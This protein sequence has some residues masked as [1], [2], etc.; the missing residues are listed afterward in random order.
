MADGW[1]N[2]YLAPVYA[3][4]ISFVIVLV[5]GLLALPKTSAGEPPN[6]QPTTAPQANIRF[7]VSRTNTPATKLNGTT[8]ELFGGDPL[9]REVN[10]KGELSLPVPKT[11]F[12]ICANLPDDW[13]ANSRKPSDSTFTCWGPFEPEKF[14]QD[15]IVLNVVSK[16]AG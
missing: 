10:E 2:R 16:P 9:T 12:T 15:G 11:R 6:P 7:L 14:K 13:S 8:V 5:A 1:R 3:L 4:V